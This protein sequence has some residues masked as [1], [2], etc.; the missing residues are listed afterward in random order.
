MSI[1]PPVIDAT[2]SNVVRLLRA[3][4][5]IPAWFSASQRVEAEAALARI[6][7]GEEAPELVDA[8]GRLGLFA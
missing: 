2:A 8:A 4:A 1:V 6:L 3:L 5:L 7:A